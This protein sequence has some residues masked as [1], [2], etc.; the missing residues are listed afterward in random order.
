MLQ[1]PLHKGDIEA[2]VSANLRF[3]PFAEN[4]SND[5]RIA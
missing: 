4:V 5:Y 3:V 2:V 1:K